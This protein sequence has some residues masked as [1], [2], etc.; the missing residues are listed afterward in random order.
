MTHIK[1]FKCRI[2][3]EYLNIALG[4][5]VWGF[6]TELLQ[7]GTSIWY[8]DLVPGTWYFGTLVPY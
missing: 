6:L 7:P 8:L 2:G 5:S 3:T 4:V 1:N